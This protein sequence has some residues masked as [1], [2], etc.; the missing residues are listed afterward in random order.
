MDHCFQ[1]H[2][3]MRP[4]NYVIVKSPREH[5]LEAKVAKLEQKLKSSASFAQI[6]EPRAGCGTS[7]SDMYMFG[8]FREVVAATSTRS[9]TLA[10]AVDS[11]SGGSNEVSHP[12]HP[13]PADQVGKARS[14]LS[15]GL[16]DTNCVGAKNLVPLK[17][18]DSISKD[19]TH[20]LTY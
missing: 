1:L 9:Q 5:C 16:V 4:A 11:T 3:E 20:A 18:G 7:G 13:G 6:S 19:V 2:P 12:L 15:F 8:A 10:D 14:P 17:D